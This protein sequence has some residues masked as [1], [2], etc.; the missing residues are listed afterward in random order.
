[1]ITIVLADDE[2]V[3]RQGLRCLLQA[4]KDFRVVGEAAE[5]LDAVR[6]VE[7]LEP[8]VL[9]VK[10]EMPQLNGLEITRRVRQRAP[11]TNVI[12]LS[13][14]ASETYVVE[15][16]RNGALAYLVRQAKGPE[17]SR[18]IR[19]VAAGKYHLSAPFSRQAIE[20]WIKR[21]QERTVDPYERL[22]SREREIF[23][24]VAE[25]NSS[26]DI[27]NRLSISPRTAEAHRANVI[28][29]LGVSSQLDLIRYA[30]ARGIVPIDGEAAIL[31]GRVA[32][33]APK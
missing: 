16:L 31:K 24:L 30:F 33:R 8:D 29:K 6:V 21:S 22:T 1:M 7:R 9:I 2:H 18:A 3:I 28:R 17:L 32:R 15:A 13:T 23:Q 12:V 14:Y 11:R 5:G 25:G 10:V 26:V 19:R 4:E 20:S 27:A